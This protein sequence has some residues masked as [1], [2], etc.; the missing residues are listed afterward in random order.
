MCRRTSTM[1]ASEAAMGATRCAAWHAA[2][3]LWRSP[4]GDAPSARLSGSATWLEASEYASP[5]QHACFACFNTAV[6]GGALC[7]QVSVDAMLMRTSS[8]DWEG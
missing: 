2:S 7:L 8:E 1:A 5:T 3:W 6:E 4:A